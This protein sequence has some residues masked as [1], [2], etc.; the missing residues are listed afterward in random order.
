MATTADFKN[1]LYFKYDGKPVSI[2]WF[3]HV[4]PGKGPAFVKTKL[5]NLENGKILDRTFTAGEKIELINVERRPYQYLYKDDMGYNFMHSE[6][7]EQ[8]S[9]QED[10]VDNADL[11][12]EGQSVEMMFLADEE[13][14]LTCELPKY[15]EME[16]TY[17]EPAVK[18]DTAST[19]AM[20]AC[21]LETGAEIMVPLFINQG[22]RIRVNTEDRSYG[23]RVR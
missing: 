3:Q 19:N 21:T 4:K 18:G 5:R 23:E 16:V 13:R 2:I 1:G 22:D 12:K 8:I 10:L 11:M 9:L 6:T 14:C 15:V 17:T 7:F 20:K